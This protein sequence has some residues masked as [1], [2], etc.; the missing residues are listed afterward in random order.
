[1]KYSST[2][3]ERP[4]DVI[5]IGSGVSGLALASLQAK[6][7][8]SVLVL[9]KHYVPGGFTHT[10]KRGGHE[11]STG[12]HYLGDLHR[13]EHPLRIVFDYVSGNKLK[14]NAL[15]EEYDRFVFPDKSYSLRAGMENF[16][17]EM[18]KHFPEERKAINEYLKLLPRMTD[19]LGKTAVASLLPS[20]LRGA[21][22]GPDAHYLQT[23]TWNVL[24]SLT[25]NERLIA[26]LTGQ[27]GNYGLPPKKSSFGVH[28]V[29]AHHY[30]N[31]G[32][33]PEGGSSSVA[34]TMISE[35]ESNGGIV[36]HSADVER[37]IVKGNEATGVELADGDK[38]YGKRIV[39]SA[40]LTNTWSKLI[41]R[42]EY[43]SHMVPSSGYVS[44]TI[45]ADIPSEELNHAGGNLWVYNDY[46]HDRAFDDYYRDPEG[47]RPPMF[48]ISFPSLKDRTWKSRIGNKTAIDVLGIGNYEWF[49]QWEGTRAHK[50]GEDYVQ[51]KKELMKPYLQALT[52]LFPQLE[53]NMNFEEI[54]TPLTVRHY[55]NYQHG[56][57]YGTELS[58]DRYKDLRRAKTPIKN[59]YLTGQD[60][61]I[62]GICGA[63]TSALVTSLAMSPLDTTSQ[64]LPLG[65]LGRK[66]RD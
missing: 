32:C 24:R 11:W 42:S 40:G 10:Y 43:L 49:R 5:I 1:M 59:F 58:A 30:L 16:R 50:R 14:W 8:R 39:S 44:L 2:L 46:D 52:G 47:K 33:F 15:P 63:L 66:L 9:E 37:V 28:G 23:S 65:V 36:A 64:L 3:A 61:L 13:E 35:I 4:Y 62:N 18:L 60:I 34:R 22:E 45:G 21:V 17:E 26:V 31:G 53:G 6:Q 48:Y 55:V 54:S 27:W 19:A 41:P 57:I 7:G 20:F 51:K 12:L 29:I 25:S 38:I 56:E